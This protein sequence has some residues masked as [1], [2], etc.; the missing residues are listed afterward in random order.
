MTSE[1][2]LTRVGLGDESAFA[3]LYERLT[4]P[5]LGMARRVLWDR[6]QAEEVTQEVMIELWRTAPRYS[7]AK[8]KALT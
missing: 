2:L 1:E 8:G 3:L 4:G 7:A 6:A 5:I